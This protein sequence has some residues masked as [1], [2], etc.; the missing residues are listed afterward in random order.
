MSTASRRLRRLQAK[1][2]VCPEGRPGGIRDPLELR[3]AVPAAVAEVK[4]LEA[5]VERLRR[6]ERRRERVC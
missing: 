6:V 2:A 5:E 1:V 3:S 4:A